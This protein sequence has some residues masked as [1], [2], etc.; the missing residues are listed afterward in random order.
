MR[1][2]QCCART[3]DPP[4]PL[5]PPQHT[6]TCAYTRAQGPDEHGSLL[7]TYVHG[8]PFCESEEGGKCVTTSAGEQQAPLY[9]KI[10][11]DSKR[12]QEVRA[13]C[14]LYSMG[15]GTFCLASR[16]RAHSFWGA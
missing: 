10:M 7:F 13:A 9:A 8:E 3:H 14:A 4:A 6:R 16:R 15:L 5:P 2:P 11:G 1:T 12:K